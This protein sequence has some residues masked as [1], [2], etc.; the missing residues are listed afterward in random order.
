MVAVT[1]GPIRPARRPRGWRAPGPPPA[2]PGDDPTL[3]PA[4][5]EDL[6]YLAGDW[7]IFQHVGG[8]RWSL[9]DL[10]TAWLA[11]E[12]VSPRPPARVADLGCGIGTVLMLLAWRFPDARVEGLEA[13]G[14]KVALAERSLRWNG[15]AG[16]CVVR[17]GDLREPAALDGPFD[18]VTGTPP[19]LPRGTATEPARPDRGPWHFEHRGGI[20]GLLS[21]RRAAARARR[22]VRRLRRHAPGG[23]RAG[24]GRGR[25][26]LRHAP[27]RRRAAG[28][29]GRALRALRAARRARGG[30]KRGAAA[31]RARCARRVDARVS[32]RAAR[33]GYADR[34]PGDSVEG[35]P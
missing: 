35:I 27:A 30:G 18:L 5:G 4:A 31:R 9:D 24:R 25:G 3:Q 33:D 22:A 19:Y 23:A 12:E 17:V 28:G 16:R 32:C 34:P 2:G 29:E 8:H 11:A 10:A 6:C 21:R 1:A 26:P 13:E 7:R 20:E 15:C 14:E